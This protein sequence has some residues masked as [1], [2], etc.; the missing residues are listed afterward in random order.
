MAEL[1]G[2]VW[3]RNADGVPIGSE[4]LQSID[5]ADGLVT[6]LEDPATGLLLGAAVFRLAGPS[7]LAAA[8]SGDHG[9]QLYRGHR[10]G[11]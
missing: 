7:L 9:I 3:G 5:H 1:F 4:M 2:A 11:A 10:T 8:R 6:I